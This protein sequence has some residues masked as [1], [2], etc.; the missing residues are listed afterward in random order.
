[1]AFTLRGQHWPEW[2]A[3]LDRWRA[4][5]LPCP[6]IFWGVESIPVAPS[7]ALT[8]KTQYELSREER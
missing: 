8:R 1:M 6:L 3:S 7:G 5:H 2:A 4:L